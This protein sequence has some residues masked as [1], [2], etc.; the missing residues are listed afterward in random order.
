L[1]LRPALRRVVDHVLGR[2][3]APRRG[4]PVRL[5]LPPVETAADV[6]VMLEAITTAVRRGTITPNEAAALAQ[7]AD[8][9]IRAIETREFDR[10]LRALEAA[11]A[12]KS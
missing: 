6:A 7:V 2:I 1:A 8:S 5:A 9:H 3:P 12:A 10:R 4:H 11:D